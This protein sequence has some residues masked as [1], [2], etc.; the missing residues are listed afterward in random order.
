MRIGPGIRF[1]IQFDVP[2]AR[3]RGVRVES[4]PSG[5]SRSPGVAEP[6]PQV[7]DGVQ[8]PAP[9]SQER[10]ALTRLAAA[11]FL[12]LLLGVAACGNDKEPPQ[13]P[14]SALVA[15]FLS[16]GPVV[17]CRESIEWQT[18]ENVV[19][20]AWARLHAEWPELR[21]DTFDDM[22]ATGSSTHDLAAMATPSSTVRFI[23]REEEDD[24][25]TEDETWGQFSEQ[26]GGATHVLR[27]CVPGIGDEGRQALIYYE[28]YGGMLRS[29]GH[30]SL[31][32]KVDGRWKP[33]RGQT[34]WFS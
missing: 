12:L 26:S 4:R 31:W 27:L 15:A 29:S 9:G 3:G 13:S 2:F 7:Q 32:V 17:V 10:N 1:D 14:R 33:I 18:R 5:A 24:L 11:V 30:F 19:G 6:A 16:P 8:P 28:W 21:R 23:T 20:D 34:Y 22:V 25:G